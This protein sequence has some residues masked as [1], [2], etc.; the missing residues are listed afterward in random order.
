MQWALDSGT[1]WD[2]VCLL[3]TREVWNS[4]YDEYQGAAA[5]R[6][7]RPPKEV[8]HT[9]GNMYVLFAFAAGLLHRAPPF[10]PFAL[11]HHGRVDLG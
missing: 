3:G 7:I 10:H 5:R 4:P 9:R 1:V 2:S 11:S 8:S 6:K